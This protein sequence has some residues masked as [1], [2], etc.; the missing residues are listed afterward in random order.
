[1]VLKVRIA[2]KSTPNVSISFPTSA[3][4]QL[5][6]QGVLRPGCVKCERCEKSKIECIRIN[7][8]FRIKLVSSVREDSPS[9]KKRC[10]KLRFVYDE[11]HQWVEVKRP[12]MSKAE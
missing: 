7:K 1:V 2:V 10:R 6:T 8:D 11:E 5:M 3:S 12:G 9:S 4:A